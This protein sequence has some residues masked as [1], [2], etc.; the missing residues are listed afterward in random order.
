MKPSAQIA[1]ALWALIAVCQP[2][3]APAG[4]YVQFSG[5]DQPATNVGAEEAAGQ[6][7]PVCLSS[8]PAPGGDQ[9]RGACCC[10]LGCDEC[11]PF[12]IVGLVGL[13]AFKGVSDGQFEDNFGTVVSLSAGMP[14]FGL[15]DYGIG[16]QI[17]MSYDA[18]DYD[19]TGWALFDREGVQQ[20]IFFTTGFFRKA[21][22]DQRLSL[23]VV[24]DWML[25]SYWG[26][27][28]TSPTLSQWRGQVEYS[29]GGCNALGAWGCLRDRG[30]EQIGEFY[31]LVTARAH[32][33]GQPVLAPQVQQHGGRQL[34]VGRRPGA[35]PAGS[36]GGDKPRRHDDRR[37]AA[38]AAVGAARSLRQRQLLSP[39]RLG[40]GRGRGR[41]RL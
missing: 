24:Y 26:M 8:D 37:D 4:D 41:Q 7:Q 17:G 9:P 18:Y 2:T 20:Q 19:G 11:P 31:S 23:G 32:E 35:R 27:F 13:D 38:I 36:R 16:W 34:F 3:A 12:G 15:R 22:D 25:N 30:S 10:D 5:G 33:P 14:V 21:H 39:Q 1:V 29:L 28:S 6:G 40:R